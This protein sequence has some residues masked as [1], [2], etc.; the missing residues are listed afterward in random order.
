[1][2]NRSVGSMVGDKT[3][4]AN[5]GETVRLFVVDAGPNLFVSCDRPDF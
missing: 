5:V 3:I 1:M 2:F 4:T